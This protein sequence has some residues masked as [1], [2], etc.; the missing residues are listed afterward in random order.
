MKIAKVKDSPTP[1]SLDELMKWIESHPQE[2]QSAMQ[3]TMART[4]NFM[5]E[6]VT[7]VSQFGGDS[8]EHL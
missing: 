7:Q 6:M 8:T 5:A 2:L 3:E 4:W 1:Q